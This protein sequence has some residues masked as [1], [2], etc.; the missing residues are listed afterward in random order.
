MS[1]FKK[2]ILGGFSGKVGSVVGS[3]WKGINVMRSLP[4]HVKKSSSV[5]LLEHRARFGAAGSFFSRAGALVR[6]GLY[7]EAIK[8]TSHNV[9]MS[10]N[11]DC[12][13]FKDDCIVVDFPRL[14]LSNG[15]HSP[16]TDVT[17]ALDS[18]GLVD[19]SWSWSGVDYLSDFQVQVMIV[20]EDLS[21]VYVMEDVAKVSEGSTKF[22]IPS[23][24]VEAKLHMYAFY[25]HPT[26][27]GAEAVSDCRYVLLSK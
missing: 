18:T 11:F 15:M 23:N 16:L 26:V 24:M 14:E 8:Q 27:R 3:T 5:K 4:A 9:A 19:L 25:V 2:G 7:P 12:F 22:M 6:K 20:T 1:T 13:Q 21:E 10:R 17:G